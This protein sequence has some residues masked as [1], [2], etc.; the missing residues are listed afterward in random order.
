MRPAL[1]ILTLLLTGPSLVSAQNQALERRFM[2]AHA[3]FMQGLAGDERYI[4]RAQALF[5]ELNRQAPDNPLFQVY[6]GG[7]YAI[8][9]REAWMPWNKIDLVEKGLEII[10]RALDKLQPRHDEMLI[11]GT[12]V[13][14][15]TRLVA[16]NTFLDLPGF[17]NRLQPAKELLADILTSQAFG[18]APD[19]IRGRVYLQA[20]AI[21]QREE[22]PAGEL[23]YL[24]QA[25]PLL[26]QNSHFLARVQKRLEAF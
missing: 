8:Q 11:R 20:A 3:A 5:E 6:L 17:F 19:E 14:I 24:K 7:T 21:A 18:L 1:F 25:K 15:E 22:N 9:G 12:P 16:L 10:D 2:A 4:D 26:R 13:G 23:R